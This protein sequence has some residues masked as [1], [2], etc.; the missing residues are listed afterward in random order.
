MHVFQGN[1]VRFTKEGTRKV[2]TLTILQYR[3]GMY[4]WVITPELFDFLLIFP[5]TVDGSSRLIHHEVAMVT[6]ENVYNS[7][8]GSTLLLPGKEMAS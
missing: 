3:F 2:D 4:N 8:V 7:S 1:E 6:R 5:L